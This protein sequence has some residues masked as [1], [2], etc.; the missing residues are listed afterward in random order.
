MN[1]VARSATL[2]A[3]LGFQDNVLMSKAKVDEY[4]VLAAVF[5]DLYP[6]VRSIDVPLSQ[7]AAQALEHCRRAQDELMQ[8]LHSVGLLKTTT[9][10]EGLLGHIFHFIRRFTRRQ[11]LERAKE[12]YR[13][14]VFLL[15]DITME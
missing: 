14:S 1:S 6:V 3:L 4:S 10:T 2:V 8:I 11:A 9:A 5:Q 15:R 13:N 7:S 12:N